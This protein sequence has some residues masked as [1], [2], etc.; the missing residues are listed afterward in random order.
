MGEVESIV[1]LSSADAE[2]HRYD[3]CRGSVPSC[4]LHVL[5]V[6]Y[7]HHFIRQDGYVFNT[8]GSL[9]VHSW[10]SLA[11]GKHV[12]TYFGCR[13]KTNSQRSCASGSPVSGF[14][15]IGN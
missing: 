8:S 10:I 13:S 11:A 1:K 12:D 14:L 9:V 15:F 7:A 4:T 6:V 2:C 5:M 3:V